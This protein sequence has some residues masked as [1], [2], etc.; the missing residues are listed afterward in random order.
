MEDKEI[1]EEE[2]LKQELLEEEEEGEE[3]TS[4]KTEEEEDTSEE[5]RKEE[6]EKGEKKE[7][8]WEAKARAMYA[9]YK[10]VK[11]KLEEL[12]KKVGDKKESSPDDWKAKVDFLLAHKDKNYTEDEFNHIAT[13][14]KEYDI[15]LEEAALLEDDY[16]QYRRE[17]V[18]KDKKIPE[19]SSP[20]RGS[21]ELSWQDIGK[22]SEE[23]HRKLWEEDLKKRKERGEGI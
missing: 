16:I 23:E 4:E 20:S 10:A 17:K 5:K 18:A 21:K 9:K 6:A 1:Q 19:P 3:D 11:E 13:V 8:D 7:P 14:A 12:E 2:E 22:M 15:S